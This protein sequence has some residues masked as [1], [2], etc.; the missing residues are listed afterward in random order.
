MT[1]GMRGASEGTQT[2]EQSEKEGR[3]AEVNTPGGRDNA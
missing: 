3:V 2:D 1:R